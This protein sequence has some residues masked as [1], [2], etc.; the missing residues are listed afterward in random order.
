MAAIRLRQDLS[1]PKDWPDRVRSAI[2]HT[3]SIATVAFTHALARVAG[4]NRATPPRHAAD[5]RLLDSA[6]R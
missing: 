1:L 2:V 3:V 6:T 4:R 5:G